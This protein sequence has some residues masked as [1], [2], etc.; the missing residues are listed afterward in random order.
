MVTERLFCTSGKFA[1]LIG[2]DAAEQKVFV[3]KCGASEKVSV[4][5]G[6]FTTVALP[7]C[8]PGSAKGTRHEEVTD[9]FA[10]GAQPPEALCQNR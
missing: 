3:Q 10:T 1:A 9:R 2:I 6:E 7:G 5:A 8:H 4:V